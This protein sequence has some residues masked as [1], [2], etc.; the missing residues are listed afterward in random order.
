MSYESS[1]T[2]EVNTDVYPKN[3]PTSLFA[4]V[5]GWGMGTGKPL[6]LAIIGDNS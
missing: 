4:N 3:Y 5:W 6:I 2:I 1:K